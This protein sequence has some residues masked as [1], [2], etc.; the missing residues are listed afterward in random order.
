MKY[1]A[2]ALCGA[3][4]LSGCASFDTPGPSGKMALADNG[5]VGYTGSRI[6]RPNGPTSHLTVIDKKSYEQE[7]LGNPAPEPLP[8][9]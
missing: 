4:L 8:V 3:V 6:A 2:L 7:M 1:P 5:A 9:F